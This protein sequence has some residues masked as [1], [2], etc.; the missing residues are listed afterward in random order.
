[1]VRR[2]ILFFVLDKW[3]AIIKGY[4]SAN[5]LGTRALYLSWQSYRMHSTQE[6][7]KIW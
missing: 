1:M 6:I 4:D 5:H 7:R 3:L 2:N